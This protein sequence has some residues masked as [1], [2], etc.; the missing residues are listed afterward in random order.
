M[1]LPLA[2]TV[3]ASAATPVVAHARLARPPRATAPYIARVAPATRLFYL[4]NV[5]L[6]SVD[7]VADPAVRALY[8]RLFA[9]YAEQCGSGLAEELVAAMCAASTERTSAVVP[10]EPRAPEV[11]A[12]ELVA[13]LAQH[14]LA[15]SFG[16]AEQLGPC[17]CLRP[18]FPPK[19]Q[20]SCGR[21]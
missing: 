4:M 7:V 15:Q 5:C 21:K 10:V 19:V 13:E 8:S 14:F 11:V 18:Q 6:Y 20:P 12:A 17:G 2:S 1:L 3:P 16:D 9:R